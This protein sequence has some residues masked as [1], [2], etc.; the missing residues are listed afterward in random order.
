MRK[1]VSDQRRLDCDAIE[2]VELN[3]NCRDEIVP[4]LVAL[5][6]IYSTPTVRDPILSLI[7][8]DVNQ[9]SRRDV[10]RE[11]FDD[12]QVLVLSFLLKFAGPVIT[13]L[14][15][16]AF[17]SLRAH[18]QRSLVSFVSRH[19]ESLLRGCA[20]RTRSVQNPAAR[21]SYAA[22]AFEGAHFGDS[23]ARLQF[24]GSVS[25]RRRQIN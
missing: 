14:A 24:L 19:L 6:Y 8:K 18:R 17:W 4:I 21:R 12:W 5:Q 13:R 23:L 20:T 2:N 3:L 9:D 16:T 10:G 7:V 25:R 15:R 22:A 1:P 11:G